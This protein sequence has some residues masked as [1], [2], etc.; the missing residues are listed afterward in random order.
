MTTTARLFVAVD[1]PAAMLSV[2]KVMQPPPQ[3]GLRLIPTAQ[4]HLTLH[5]LGEMPVEPVVVA[6]TGFAGSTFTLTVD[7]VG[8]FPSAARP[9][10]LWTGFRQSLELTNLHKALGAAL[11]TTGFQP[12]SRSYHPHI[13]LARCRPFLRRDVVTAFLNQQEPSPPT[14]FAVDHVSLYSSTLRPDGAEYRE[15]LRIPLS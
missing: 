9:S 2:L 6:L 13:T 7:G 15:E 1:L 8:C 11:A 5:F 4:M 12:E 3:P 14:S 10:I